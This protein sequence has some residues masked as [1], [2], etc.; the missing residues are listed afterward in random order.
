M[1]MLYL[2]YFHFQQ[3]VMRW[4]LKLM[5]LQY[6]QRTRQALRVQLNGKANDHSVKT[7]ALSVIRSFTNILNWPKDVTELEAMDEATR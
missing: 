3:Y 6:L 4:S 7:L 5:L 2:Q 1:H